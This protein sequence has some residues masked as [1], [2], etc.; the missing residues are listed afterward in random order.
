MVD[1][2]EKV[3]ADRGLLKKI[4]VHVP[5]F[6]GYRRKEDIRAADSLLRLQIADRLHNIHRRLIELLHGIERRHIFRRHPDRR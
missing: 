4:Q 6:A 1:L 2:R 3:E 5:G